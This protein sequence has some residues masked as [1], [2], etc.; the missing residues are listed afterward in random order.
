MFL[1]MLM[2]HPVQVTDNT[3]VSISGV[4]HVNPDGTPNI[5]GYTTPSGFF[6]GPVIQYLWDSGTKTLITPMI[7]TY[8]ISHTGDF[9]NDADGDIFDVTLR[10]WGPCNPYD[11]M[12]SFYLPSGS[13]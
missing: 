1:S 4:W 8:P 7:Q 12:R 9:V 6:E 13:Y 11:G 10:N 2:G 3:G 5:P